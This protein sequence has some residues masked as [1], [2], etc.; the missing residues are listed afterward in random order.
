MSIEG[1]PGR[2]IK[3]A[4]FL[5]RS[6]ISNATRPPPD[7]LSGYHAIERAHADWVGRGRREEKNTHIMDGE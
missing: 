5:A 1:G 7:G 2:P 4:R 3:D 6:A